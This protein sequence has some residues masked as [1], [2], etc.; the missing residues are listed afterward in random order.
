MN[1]ID[2]AIYPLNEGYYTIGFD[3]V[4]YP[5]DKDKD[6]L[7]DRSRGSL[8]VE[9]QPFLIV[10]PTRKILLDTG[11][12]FTNPD[13]GNLK[14]IDNLAK[15]ELG[16]DE[17]T[18][19]VMSH[20]HKDHAGGFF[21]ESDG[22]LELTFSNA[23]VHINKKEFN[24][25]TDDKNSLSYNTELIK[26]LEQKANILWFTGNRIIDFIEY[27]E[28]GGHCPYHS[29][30]LLHTSKGKYF[31]GGDVA[32]QLKQLK[33]RYIAKYDFDGKRSLELRTGYAAKGKEEDWTFLFYHDVKLPMSKV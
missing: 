24:F 13:T 18:D 20:L 4:F 27:K 16:A 28:D 9:I 22:Q 11:L 14:I 5:F 21:N 12:G 10:T 30:L 29:S 32:P 15:H 7:E 23:R 1:K 2:A 33:F 26:L 3:K 25:A 19:I 8:L 31:F 6:I 17:I